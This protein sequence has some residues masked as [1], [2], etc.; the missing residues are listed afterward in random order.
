LDRQKR[1]G[2]IIMVVGICI[3]LVSLIFCTGYKPDQNIFKNLYSIGIPLGKQTP[4]KVDGSV[5][6]APK[7]KVTWETI[8]NMAPK[9]IGFRFILAFGVFIIFAGFMRYDAARQKAGKEEGPGE[10]ETENHSP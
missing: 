10:S 5:N 1:A 9:S 7:G 3:P 2:I 6:P 8:R 4:E